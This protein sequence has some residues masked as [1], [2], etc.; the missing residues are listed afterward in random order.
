LSA[1][2]RI[3]VSASLA[4]QIGRRHTHATHRSLLQL[5]HNSSAFNWFLLMK[6]E[7]VG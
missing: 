4:T 3:A 1:L 6:Q 5:S 2:P 7:N